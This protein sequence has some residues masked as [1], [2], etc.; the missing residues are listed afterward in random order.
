MSGHA[1]TLAGHRCS[2]EGLKPISGDF[3]A[4]AAPV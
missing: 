3:S 4:G 1:A 2:G